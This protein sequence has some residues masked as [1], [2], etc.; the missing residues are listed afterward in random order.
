MTF[1]GSD[2][3]AQL[4][5]QLIDDARDQPISRIPGFGRPHSVLLEGFTPVSKENWGEKQVRRVLSTFAYSG[6]ATDHQIEVWAQMAPTAAIVQMLNFDPVNLRLSPQGAAD[7]SSSYCHSLEELQNF[8]SSD[9]TNNPMRL[10]NRPA[11]A[12]LAQRN[13][14]VSPQ[15]LFLAWSRLMHTP[16]CNTFLHKMALYITNYHASIHIQNA[17]PS[18]IRSYYDDVVQEL[19]ASGDFV[20]VM[21]LA[22]SHAALSRAYGHMGNL[23]NRDGE[24]IGND[25]FAREYFQLLFGIQGLSE[26]E[27]YHEDVTIEHNGWLLTGMILDTEPDVW[28][29]VRRSDW[30]IAP[31]VFTDH[32]D[33]SGRNIPN[34]SVHYGARNRDGNCL[35][36]L[37]EQICGSN[38]EEKLQNLGRVAASHPESMASIPV[39]FIRFFG[40]DRLSFEEISALQT[41]WA[42]ARF[43]IL[44]FIQAYAISTQFLEGDAF[45]L[46]SAFDRNLSIH[47]AKQLN[48]E[49]A[50]AE[51]FRRGPGARMVNQGALVFAPIRDVFGGQ[52][53]ADAAND[54]F[55]FKNAWDS[56]I[57]DPGFLI[58][59]TSSYQLET[60]G[61]EHIWQKD[62][63]AVIPRNSQGEHIASAVGEWLWKRFIGDDGAN[64]DAHARAQVN[65]M[66][67]A[68]IDFG[69]AFDTANPDATYGTAEL[70]GG[71]PAQFAQ[72]LARARLNL[73]NNAGNI[74]VG[75]AINFI[76]ALPYTF[77]IGGE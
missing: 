66:L 68:G 63:S 22:A 55:V 56:N 45:K 47:N 65:A 25:D 1:L 74:R 27:N 36:I 72:N 52:T 53:G 61:V 21:T 75:M 17:G 32:I 37:H 60:D 73:A 11:Y 69:A 67:V 51:S 4:P 40:D 35:E 46:K 50:Y 42:D 34:Q 28:G 41:A 70:S 7:P 64:F 6:Q 76:T 38:A 29:S 30:R 23:F 24:F 18:L 14:V 71:L 33:A 15:N 44:N 43:S 57:T 26:E 12:T 16:G 19:S 54:R 13:A 39:K 48:A 2:A 77:V 9:D 5:P 8:W 3:F 20:N 59:T 49:E 10:D 31:I 58:Q 62:W